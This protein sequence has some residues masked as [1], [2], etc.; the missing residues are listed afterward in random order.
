[1][2]AYGSVHSSATL[3]DTPCIVSHTFWEDFL[4]QLQRAI[5]LILRMDRSPHVLAIEMD[6]GLVDTHVE[7]STCDGRNITPCGSGITR[8]VRVVVVVVR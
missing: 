1:M 6:Q 7:P 2:V 8:V 5:N 3:C 4:E